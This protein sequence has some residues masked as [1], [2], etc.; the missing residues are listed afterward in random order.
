MQREYLLCRLKTDCLVGPGGVYL[1]WIIAE[2]LGNSAAAAGR[3][4]CPN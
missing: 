3:S 4:I 2:K 1:G